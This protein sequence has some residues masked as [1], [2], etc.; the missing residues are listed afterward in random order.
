MPIKSHEIVVK[1]PFFPLATE[2]PPFIDD[3][4][5]KTSISLGDFHWTLLEMSRY[6]M[7][8]SP[9]NGEYKAHHVKLCP[10]D[11]DI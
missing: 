3:F 6:H 4:P 9:I 8:I 7:G 1:F 5:I 10:H 11:S 2:N